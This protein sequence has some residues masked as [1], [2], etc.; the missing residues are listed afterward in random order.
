MRNAALHY[1]RA[2]AIICHER[3]WAVIVVIARALSAILR[4]VYGQ[5]RLSHYLP[6]AN[7]YC[8]ICRA[9]GI[10]CHGQTCAVIVVIVRTFSAILW[11]MWSFLGQLDHCVGPLYYIICR[12]AAIICRGRP[13][14]SLWSLRVH[15]LPFSGMGGH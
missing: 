14:R 1:L 13:G 10:I 8:I 6:C 15:Y 11:H 3:A 5:S 4:H 12:A 9:A 7:L 2:A